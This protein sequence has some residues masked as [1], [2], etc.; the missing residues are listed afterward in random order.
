[1]DDGLEEMRQLMEDALTL[2]TDQAYEKVGADVGA[3]TPH[4][5]LPHDAPPEAGGFKLAA[6]RTATRVGAATAPLVLRYRLKQGKEDLARSSE[7]LGFASV[8][9]PPGPLA[10][11]HAASVGETNA[12]LPLIDRLRARRPDI[13]FLVTTGTV[14]SARLA[15]ER[16]SAQDIHQY[17][18]W[19]APHFVAR[20][21]DHWR[22]GLAVLT[23]SEIWP[24]M[25][26]D[27]HA[28]DIPIAVVNGRM[29]DRSYWRWRRNKGLSHA[30]FG[31]LRVV[32]AQSDQLRRRFLEL[33]TRHALAVGNLKADA[34]KLPV[35]HNGLDA[36]TASTEGR[37]LWLAAS[38]HV[39]EDEIV[40]DVHK[41]LAVERPGLLTI[42]APRHPDRGDAIVALARAADMTVSQRSNGELPD[43]ETDIYV[44]DTIGEMGLLYSLAP[45]AFIGGS[46]VTKGGQNPIEAVRFGTNIVTGPNRSNFVEAYR[47][48]L[49]H[50]G[51]IAVQTSD[52]LVAAVDLLLR[53]EV[54]QARLAKGA[55]AALDSLTGALERTAEELLALLPSDDQGLQRAS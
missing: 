3:V 47:A 11:I 52:D 22:P 6:Y 31:R 46:L 13:R 7:R 18:P 2:A 45:I 55:D 17:A 15:A 19:D 40:L 16:L 49:N 1:A 44:A 25:I 48:L 30:L 54:E 41:R 35:D 51:A 26:V 23:E 50:H 34:P 36:L 12:I 29:S 9:R 28:R 14:T 38:T 10:W 37:S 24:N 21:L 53:D 5:A 42:I 4:T 43:S 33:G 32:L 27:C 8:D 39:G 20:F